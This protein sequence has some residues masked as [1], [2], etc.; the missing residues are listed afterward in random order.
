MG[1]IGASAP[2]AETRLW[3]AAYIAAGGT[4]TNFYL[5]RVDRLIRALKSSGAWDLTD[6]YAVY[7]NDQATIQPIITLK[8]LIQQ[9]VQSSPVYVQARGELGNQAGFINTGWIPGTGTPQYSR[10]SARYGFFC[11][12]APAHTGYLMGFDDN[13]N[14]EVKWDATNISYGVNNASAFDSY[15]HGGNVIGWHTFERTGATAE[16]AYL[17][18]VQKGTGTATST[19]LQTFQGTVLSSTR[20]V[21]GTLPTDGG[22]SMACWGAPLPT[23]KA[24]EYAAINDFMTSFP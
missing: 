2:I 10:N 20:G 22:I 8:A 19:T 13:D 1:S 16:A 9:S 11:Y 17:N 4:L 7:R 12:Q 23:Q 6:D 21:G 18:T 3:K 24:A 14:G 5:S 15:A